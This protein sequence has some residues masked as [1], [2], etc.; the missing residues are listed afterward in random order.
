MKLFLVEN[1]KLAWG[2]HAS[3]VGAADSEEEVRLFHPMTFTFSP[4]QYEPVYEDEEDYYYSN[5][6]LGISFTTKGWES[7]WT[8]KGE[9]YYDT[10]D[11]WAFPKDLKVKY[12]GE[13]AP[14]IKK[15]I[16]HLHT[17]SD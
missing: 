10:E 2:G 7:K 13:A 5:V 17:L 12:I 6:F 9:I 8:A 3:F 16:L 14:D 1:T 11:G 4:P 15:G